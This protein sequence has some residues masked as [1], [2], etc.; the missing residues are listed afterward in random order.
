M[1]SVEST[2]SIQRNS[3]ACQDVIT[4]NSTR[5]TT[6]RLPEYWQN[7][8]ISI[9]CLPARPY[10]AL[11]SWWWVELSPE[12]CRIK[13]LRR[14]NTIVASCWN[15]FTMTHRGLEYVAGWIS[16]FFFLSFWR[17]LICL[18]P[19]FHLQWVSNV[20]VMYDSSQLVFFFRQHFFL[21][22]EILFLYLT[23]FRLSPLICV[24]PCNPCNLGCL[25]IIFFCQ[26]VVY[27]LLF[28]TT[29]LLFS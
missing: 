11:Y 4:Y 2:L 18:Y 14:I 24:G 27:T 26:N 28:I 9:P 21:F 1:L 15:Y 5:P 16:F 12:T 3:T 8:N 10:T 13:P 19:L 20:L 29:K 22:V 6:I 23:L 17:L 25:L 7:Y